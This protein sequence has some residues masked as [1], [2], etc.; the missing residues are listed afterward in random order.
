[1]PTRNINLTDQLD[2]F[3][4]SKIQSGRYANVS[5]VV[6]AGLRALQEDEAE[7]QAKLECM[8]NAV[9]EAETIPKSEWKDGETAR[10]RTLEYLSD[11]VATEAKHEKSVNG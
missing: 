6:R 11:L 1:M 4:T 8:R 3:I 7:D 9:A 5:E 2:V 10:A